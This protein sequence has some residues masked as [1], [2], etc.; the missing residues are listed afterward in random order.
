[1]QAGNEMGKKHM[2]ILFGGDVVPR[3]EMGQCLSSVDDVDVYGA[4]SSIVSRSDAFIVNLECPLSNSSVS[5]A[6]AGPKLK[7]SPDVAAGLARMGISAVSMANNHV[8]DYGIMGVK[9]TF[10]TL[11]ENHISYFG[12]GENV[13]KASKPFFITSNG[14]KVGILAFAEHEFNWTSD[15]DWCSSMLD[16]AANVLQITETER[17]CDA[18]VVFLHSGPENWHYPSPRMV[19]TARAYVDAGASAVINS[20]AHSVMGM[21]T[22][23]GAP[24]YYGLG[25]LL[26]PAKNRKQSWYQG[27]MVGLNISKD[28]LI[29]YQV[30]HTKFTERKL[31]LN[32]AVGNKM[33]FQELCRS[34]SEKAILEQKWQE[35]CKTQKSKFLK[36]ISKGV[37]AMLPH[38]VISR[39]LRLRIGRL[40]KLYIKGASLLRGLTVCENHIDVMGKIFDMMRTKDEQDTHMSRIK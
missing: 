28:G 14:I 6:K 1:M 13:Q 29:D 24:I 7:A 9:D 27:L 31:T 16:P 32:D 5:V 34:I 17:N 25:N 38:I 37:C 35:F 8:M 3:H 30:H 18:V 10:R 23:N 20:H 12:V 22:Y 40:Q 21:E 4:I 36:E 19:K 15:D 33:F 2:S 11:K 26:F 39:I